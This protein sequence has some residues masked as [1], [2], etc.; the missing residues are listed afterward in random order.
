MN[1][2]MNLVLFPKMRGISGLVE[3]T[4]LSERFCSAENSNNLRG[5]HT[6]KDFDKGEFV[7]F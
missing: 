3:E 6:T 1:T 2:A 5:R 7:T 4:L